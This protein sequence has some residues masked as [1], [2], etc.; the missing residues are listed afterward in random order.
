MTTTQQLPQMV[1]NI[2]DVFSGIDLA[3]V[4][5]G[6]EW[7]VE[8]R[9]LA[10]ELAAE[11]GYSVDQCAGVIAA[12]SPMMSWEKNQQLAARVLREGGLTSGY[13]STGLRKCDA[14]LAGAPIE[15]TLSGLKIRNFY[16]S[17]RSAGAQGVCVDR[18]AI[19]IALNTRHSDAERPSL[20]PKQYDTFVGA[21]VAA[22]E[23][24]QAQGLDISPAELQSATWVAWRAEHGGTRSA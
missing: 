8:A 11:T 19:D 12:T 16:L 6:V 21:Y 10:E 23:E 4:S 5:A 20:T 22:A 14:I 1:K 7:Y 17:I 2:L 18:H 9:A 15:E 13:L 3:D 24:L